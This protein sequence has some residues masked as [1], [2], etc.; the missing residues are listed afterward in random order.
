MLAR[1]MLTLLLRHVADS[2]PPRFFVERPGG[3]STPPALVPSPVGFPIAGRPKSDLWRE[4]G[5]YL[6]EFLGY[7]F[8]PET[9][10]AERV[11][12][13]LRDW[14]KKAFDA[15]FDSRE[16]G[17]LIDDA[18]AET[19]PARGLLQWLA[20]TEASQRLLSGPQEQGMVS[21][22]AACQ[23]RCASRASLLRA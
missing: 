4:L 12:D 9:E 5:W 23:T 8:S 22:M 11:L 14:G 10:H 19:T 15:L 20:A 13:A 17:T 3:K 21:G 16:G 18:T 6:E 1:P 7:P 2:D